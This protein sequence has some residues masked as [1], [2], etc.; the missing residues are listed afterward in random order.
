MTFLLASKID[1]KGVLKRWIDKQRE[2]RL[3]KYTL[4]RYITERKIRK[5]KIILR[6]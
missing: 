4:E 3:T 6:R 2:E 1:T 5:K